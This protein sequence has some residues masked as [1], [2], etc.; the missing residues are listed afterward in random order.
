M[1][2]QIETEE[3]SQIDFSELKHYCLQLLEL[4]QNPR[5][6]SHTLSQLHRFLLRSP[7]HS[8]QPFFDY[9]LFPLL[10]L[11]DRAVECRSKVDSDHSKGPL[12]V[13]DSVAEGALKCLEELLKVSNRIIRSD[14]YCFEE[15]D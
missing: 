11:L 5:K 15:I 6:D 4:L 8:L 7:P 12:T 3:S 14:G 2:L 10:L 13:S 9:T 1:E